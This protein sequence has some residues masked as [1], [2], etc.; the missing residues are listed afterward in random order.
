M[1]IVVS[2]S[3]GRTSGFMAGWL[4]KHYKDG[5]LKFVFANTGL[6]HENTLIFVDKL[7]K[8]FNLD[9]QW[10]EADVQ[11]KKGDGTRFKKVCFDTASRNGKP[12]EDV[13]EK[14]GIPSVAF[15]HC[16][17]EL[18]VAP[19]DAWA[20]ENAKGWHKAIGIRIDEIDRMAAD[21]K[22]RK[23]IYPLISMVKANKPMV[24]DFWAKMPF[25]LDLEEHYG[26]CVTCYKKTDRK[27]F[28]ILKE[29]PEWFD[30][31]ERMEKEHGYSK[32]AGKEKQAAIFFRG[33]RTVAMLKKEL[34][35]MGD[36]FQ[37]FTEAK[38]LN[39]ID[40]FGGNSLDILDG[41]EESCEAF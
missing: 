19:I 1:D 16:T 41:C 26:N 29:T 31:F 9:L 3:G 23:I 5:D 8:Y 30:F 22:K 18:K 4:K 27:L 38:R 17:R 33:N 10:L 28:T 15:P 25:D 11:P 37:S 12:F 39:Q 32:I 14:Y 40:M 13:I 36:Q 20:R 7:D 35:D 6:E 21:A 34:L 24:L 2:V